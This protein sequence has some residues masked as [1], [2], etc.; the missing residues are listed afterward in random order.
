MAEEWK[1][2]VAEKEAAGL[3]TAAAPGEFNAAKHVPT[4]TIADGKAT[5]AVPHGMDEDHFIEYVLDHFIL[6]HP[7]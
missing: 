1:T 2:A 6:A 4:V 7:C 5:V 3:F